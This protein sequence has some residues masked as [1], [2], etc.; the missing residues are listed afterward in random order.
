MTG[1]VVRCLACSS[2][3]HEKEDCEYRDQADS[4]RR[5]GVQVTARELREIAE[6]ARR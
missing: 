1:N 4:M 6:A 5:A 3:I 2:A